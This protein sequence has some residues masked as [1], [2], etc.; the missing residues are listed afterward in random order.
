MDFN[1]DMENE[2]FIDEPESEELE[3]RQCVDEAVA[4]NLERVAECA[5]YWR[6]H[7][8]DHVTFRCKEDARR[9]LLL[10]VV[11]LLNVGWKP[12]GMEASDEARTKRI[13]AAPIRIKKISRRGC[14]SGVL[15]QGNKKMSEGGYLLG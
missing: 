11:D 4:F 6:D 9:K 2:E 7:D 15:D 5:T 13:L 3:L 12:K 8:G 14:L 1:D 10:A